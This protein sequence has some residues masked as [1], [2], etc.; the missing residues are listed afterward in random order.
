VKPVEV[1][2]YVEVYCPYCN[3]V[4]K[5]ILRDLQVRYSEINRKLRSEGLPPIP[6][7]DI[8]VIDVN[9]TYDEWYE[10]Y[11]R[12]VGGRAT[13]VI[14]VGNSIFYLFGRDKPT[15]LQQKQLSA[16]SLLKSQIIEKLQQMATSVE[17]EPSLDVRIIPELPIN[18][19]VVD[20]TGIPAFWRN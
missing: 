10:T 13:P 20:R 6:P 14:K 7:I 9:V 19:R 11:S 18:Y 5:Y 4:H 12:K 1:K 8:R 2:L 3:Y 15:T 17:K 16:T